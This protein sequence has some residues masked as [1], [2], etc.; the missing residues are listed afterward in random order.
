VAAARSVQ[1]QRQEKLNARL[2]PDEVSR[3][4][5]LAKEP[6]ALLATVIARLGLSA[7]AYHRVLKVA[8]TC[9]DLGGAPD[10]RIADVAEAV[11]LRVLDRPTC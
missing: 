8:R 1:L 9:A 3:F 11:K 6:R 7:R 10:I 2:S 4:C 5:G